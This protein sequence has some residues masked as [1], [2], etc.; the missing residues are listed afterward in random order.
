VGF[1]HQDRLSCWPDRFDLGALEGV[2]Q[3]RR[4]RPAAGSG[5][6]RLLAD[7]ALLAAKLRE[8]AAELAGAG[9][10]A[11][12]VHET[13]D[14]FYMGMVALVRSGGSLA[15]VLAELE[16]RHGAASRRPMVAK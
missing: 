1:C 11:E 3:T 9:S 7:G 15:E 4:D 5:T 12:A 6:A 14:L 2:I 8:E 13:A 16:R 10:A